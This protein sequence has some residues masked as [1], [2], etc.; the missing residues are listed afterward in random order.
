M[1]QRLD[2]RKPIKHVSLQNLSIYYLWK[3]I[4]KQ[5]KNNKLKKIAPTWNNE[6][7]IPDGSNSML[8]IQDYIKYI[9]RKHETLTEISFIHFYINIINNRLVF[10][11]KDG[12]KL[13]LQMPQTIKLFGITKKLIDKT[14]NGEN[15]QVLKSLK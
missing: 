3:N 7:D 4:R 10:E 1:S 6:F 13:E 8:D 11:V 15:Y 5:Y 2:L 12:Y 14:K 9:I